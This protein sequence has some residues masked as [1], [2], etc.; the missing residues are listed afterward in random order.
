M[1]IKIVEVDNTQIRKNTRVC[2]QTKT[3]VWR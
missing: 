2:L 3:K 1:E